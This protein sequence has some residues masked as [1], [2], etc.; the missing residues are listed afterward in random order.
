MIVINNPSASGS[1]GGGAGEVDDVPVGA[2]LLWYSTSG[3]L[4]YGYIICDGSLGTSNM[5]GRAVMG[6]TVAGDL[7]AVGGNSAHLHPG[8]TSSSDGN[9]N[10]SI[11]GGTVGTYST[12]STEDAGDNARSVASDSHNHSYTGNN[13]ADNGSHSHAS[14]GNTASANNTPLAKLFYWIKRVA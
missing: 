7:L 14:S 13:S 1:S 3:S 2:I 5:L 8:A 9:H 11:P 10:H 12:Y 6:A 4:P